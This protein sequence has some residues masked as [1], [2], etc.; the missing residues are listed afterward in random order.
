MNKKQNS[1]FK[2]VKF[3]IIMFVSVIVGFFAGKIGFSVSAAAIPKITLITLALLFI[4]IFF[5]VIGIHEAGHAAAGVLV[6]FDFKTYIVGPFMWN[7][8]QAGWKFKWNKNV[9]TAGGLVICLPIGTKNLSKRFSIYAASGPIASLLLSALAYG[10]FKLISMVNNPYNFIIQT[11]SYSFFI[12]AVFSMVIFIVTAI[13][14]HMGGFSSDGARVMHLLGGGDKAR[15]E[16]L[17]LKLIANSTSGLRPKLFNLDELTEAE[18]LAKKLNA[19]F[20]VYLHGLFHQVAFDNRELEKAEQYLLKYINASDEIPEGI[21]NTV[22]LDAAFFYAFAQQDITEA[23]KYWNLFKPTALIPKA[24]VF[25][26]EAAICNLKKEKAIA[27]SK[28]E[29]SLREIPNMI[30]KGMGIALQDKLLQLKGN[31]EKEH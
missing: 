19:P 13:P 3:W 30:D 12:M 10:V 31:I 28:I 23:S 8:E 22:W 16:V 1:Q 14:M 5:I 20:A 21:R 7:K 27:L 26:T 11:A 2:S 15:F 17:V 18:V 4:P 24:Q 25:A 6:N 9:N 29:K